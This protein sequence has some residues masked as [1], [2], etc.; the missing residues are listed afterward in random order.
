MSEADVTL[1]HTA[2][3]RF[4]AGVATSPQ[5]IAETQALRYR[6]FAGE[7]GAEIDGGEAGL[8]IDHYDPYCQHLTVRETATGRLVAC[9][10]ILTDDQAIRAG[11]FYSAGEFDLK[12]IDSLPGRVME[13][14]RTCVD[15]EFRNGAVIAVLWQ[16]LAEFIIKNG[17]DYLFGCAS[18]GLEDGGANAHA[19]LR[20]IQQKYMAESWQ[21]VRPLNPLPVADARPADKAPRLPPLL[22]AYFSL[23]AKACGEPYWDREFNCADVFVLLNVTDLHPRYARH[24]LDRSKIEE[25]T[26]V[27]GR[28]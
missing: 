9:T 7:M 13:V 2:G 11:G 25:K 28:A 14:G 18:I 19:I 17:F 10:R 12:M 22:K 21:Q 8:D 26:L 15:A 23:G 3:P 27:A 4:V 16:A 5:A 20:Q 6:I 24:F 1:S